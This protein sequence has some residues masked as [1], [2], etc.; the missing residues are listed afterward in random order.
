MKLKCFLLFFFFILFLIR[1]NNAQTQLD[2]ITEDHIGG[3]STSIVA[4]DQYVF[5][6]EAYGLR[7]LNFNGT[8]YSQVGSFVLSN[9][10]LV[11][12]ADN[13]NLFI[14]SQN[15]L[16]RVNLS[17][18]TYLTVPA[19]NSYGQANDEI[20][21]I[22][23][24]SDK[25]YITQFNWLTNT[26]AFRILNKTN[27]ALLGSLDI[28]CQDVC[29]TGTIAYVITGHKNIGSTSQYLK[30]YNVA[31]LPVITEVGSIQLEGAEKLVVR[32]NYAYVIGSD[33]TGITVVDISNPFAPVVLGTNLAVNDQL[34]RIKY[35]GNKLYVESAHNFY[36]VDITNPVVPLQ[37]GSTAASA[38]YN[39]S[40]STFTA[41]DQNEY[42]LYIADG[43]LNSLNVTNPQT[44]VSGP[45]NNSPNQMKT[46]TISGNNLFV[47]D[48]TS[49][50][51]YDIA[52]S[53][54]QTK[55]LAADNKII[56]SYGSNLYIVYDEDTGSRLSIIDI[57]DISFPQQ[58]GTY[59]TGS[60]ISRVTAKGNYVYLLRE[61]L[62]IIEVIN[63]ATP[64]IPANMFNYQL[65]GKGTTLFAAKESDKNI[66]YAG[67][68]V[69]ESSKGVELIDISNPPASAKLSTI[70]TSGKPQAIYADGNNLY[71][72]SHT[73]DEQGWYLEAFNV[74]ST[75]NP[76]Q[77]AQT[78][79]TSAGEI[80]W[81]IFAIENR[82][83][84][85]FTDNGLKTY[86]LV[87]NS[88]S[89]NQS[90]LPKAIFLLDNSLAQTSESS[91]IHSTHEIAAYQNGTDLN[92]YVNAD[93]W[94]PLANY[95][96]NGYK[97]MYKLKIPDF[98]P[99]VTVNKFNLTMGVNPPEYVQYGCTTNPP[100]GGPYEKDWMEVV[101]ISAIDKPEYGLYFTEWTGASGDKNTTIV[102]DNDKEVIANFVEITLTASGTAECGPMCPDEAL[103]EPLKF[104]P[105]ILC[106][107]PATGWAVHGL[108]VKA[109]GTGDDL[110]DIKSLELYDGTALKGTGK[111]G[112]DNGQCVFTFSSPIV[113]PANE[114]V[115]LDL[116][117][118]FEYDA[119]DYAVDTNYT[120]LVEV[121]SINA[122]PLMYPEGL[123]QGSPESDQPY[124][125][126]RVY[127]SST[128]WGFSKIQ[129]AIDNQYTK[130]DDTCYVCRGEYNESISVDKGIHL[131]G[132]EGA[133]KTTVNSGGKSVLSVTDGRTIQGFTFVGNPLNQTPIGF[134]RTSMSFKFVDNITLVDWIHIYEVSSSEFTNNKFYNLDLLQIYRSFEAKITNNQGISGDNRIKV[135]S[136]FGTEISGNSEFELSLKDN[137][138]T[139][140]KSKRSIIKNND[141]KSISMWASEENEISGNTISGGVQSVGGRQNMITDN[142][143]FSS[144]KIGLSLVSEKWS[145]VIDN[146]I[147]NNQLDGINLYGGYDID[148]SRNIVKNNT[149]RGIAVQG[150]SNFTNIY[151]NTVSGHNAERMYGVFIEDSRN[152][153]VQLN[154]VVNNCTGIRVINSRRTYL[155]LNKVLDASCRNTGIS[156]NNSSP[157]IFGNTIENNT[158][159][160][161]FAENG[162]NPV[163]NSNNI[164]GNSEKSISNSDP[165]VIISASGNWWGNE[166][167]PSPNDF[168]GNID[169]EGWLTES[170]SLLCSSLKDTL[171]TASGKT[172]STLVHLQNMEYPDDVVDITVSDEMG[173]LASDESFTSQLRDSNGISVNIVFNVPG[174]TNGGLYDKVLIT[175]QSH[176]DMNV[177]AK[178]S[179]YISTYISS[180]LAMTISPDSTT[181]SVGDSIQFSVSGIDQYDNVVEIA[182]V[183]QANMG[184]ISETG[185]FICSTAGTAM[186]AATDPASGM[187]TQTNVLITEQE[188]QLAQIKINP[189]SVTVM[190]GES[191]LFEAKGYSQ[192]GFPMQPDVAWSCSGGYIDSYGIYTAD[193]IAGIFTITAEDTLTGVKGYATVVINTIV[194]V[195][196]VE[197]PSVYKLFQNYPNPFNPSTTIRYALPV[198]SEV[199]IEVL[200]ILGER[201]TELV[202][203]IQGA[204]YYELRFDASAI[205]SG[206]YFYVISASPVP[207]GKS[208]R[209]VNKMMLI[210]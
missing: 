101:S 99:P 111:Y 37:S 146:T 130:Y 178:D 142:E 95:P 141:L 132:I 199:N 60:T 9:P 193:S 55:Y 181:I 112:A 129:E 21:S 164:F 15:N 105:F 131:I 34:R 33:R 144:D 6:C 77:M 71:I 134:T 78:S 100:P 188:V 165:S 73:S 182:P 98:P 121:N 53:D 151:G 167:G 72:G 87:Q 31:A 155:D 161:I 20:F 79:N 109:N 184:E 12:Y 202:K 94:S 147:H 204:G 80:I 168:E 16:V 198:E 189:D 150:K 1:D 92:A 107:S 83:L 192:L 125:I 4:N 27:L 2:I 69:S 177:F 17:D 30:V 52:N 172:D 93:S 102:M 158:G 194:S 11:T 39:G 160:G 175:A 171:Y 70:P 76:V 108:T 117:Y 122:T 57:S 75:Q 183:W 195:R 186:I 113:V 47:G 96:F 48:G 59:Q 88:G 43:T 68:Y 159:N 42:I 36:I 190:P 163:I 176:S 148:I 28:A 104:L 29:V 179:F 65:T 124:T 13:S 5:L 19:S 38:S 63:V 153:T 67:Y 14:G 51:K 136:S 149:G 114:C 174:N 91:N 162:S 126:A 128:I 170:A 166:T 41:S 35:S 81:D 187:Q 210:K 119:E 82:L 137:V 135:I 61:E 62:D 185:L 86:E 18:V 50:W 8:N 127:T 203:E 157:R 138:L 208:F 45:Q 154:K 207:G 139:N 64:T 74:A 143:I 97:G 54:A 196:E 89:T 145:K 32:G 209:S 118:T 116:Y 201:V 133:E 44:P 152:T 26:G 103:K 200:N 66:L 169:I 206:I 191:L 22:F 84:V 3:Y 115:E 180:I 173:W 7:V 46:M 197:I 25:V 106:A 140:E 56:S 10:G 49:I 24:E 205:S 40:F 156:L 110:N 23:P 123:I 90:A 85:S 120:F 58:K